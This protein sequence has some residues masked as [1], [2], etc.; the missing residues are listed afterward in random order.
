MTSMHRHWIA[1]LTAGLLG[2]SLV[3]TRVAEAQP[4][5]VDKQKAKTAK[6][7]VDAGL[8]AQNDKDYDT[9]IS[10][11]LKAYQLIPHPTLLFNLGQAHRL[12]GKLA[13]AKTYYEKYLAA[14][15]KGAHAAV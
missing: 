4:Q 3:A 2:G 14:D 12:A 13:D 7:Y 6:Q 9:A 1:L 11:Y 15:P 8:A 10:L 5:K